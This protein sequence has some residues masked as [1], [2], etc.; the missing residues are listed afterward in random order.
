[1]HL[2]VE[3]AMS[4]SQQFEV[5]SFE[6][7]DGM[8][9]ELSLL[10]S[11][12]EAT[13][14]RLAL[15]S[16]V[17][18]AARSLN[19][20]YTKKGRGSESESPQLEKRHRR[21]IFGSRGSGSDLLMQTDDELTASNRKCEELAQELWRL[22]KR[23]GEI[24]MRLLHHTAGILQMTHKNL[25]KDGQNGRPSSPESMLMSDSRGSVP[26]LV[27]EFDERSLYRMLDGTDDFGGSL[28]PQNRSL[29]Q[30][31]S[32]RLSQSPE[33]A[34]Q[35]DTII[36]TEKKLEHLNSRLRV[37]IMHASQSQD[38]PYEAPPSHQVNGS[39]P[40]PGAVIESQLAYL[41]KGLETIDRQSSESL[42]K[43]QEEEL[44]LE[45]R[46]EELNHQLH[47]IIES[48]PHQ[49]ADYHP[50]PQAS[51]QTLQSQLDYLE[52]GMDTI[53]QR[54][55]G[56]ARDA[57]RSS[58][59]FTG[60][61]EKV[62]QYNT[63]LMG[64]WEIILSGEEEARQRRRE[65][66]ETRSGEDSDVSQEESGT[67][68]QEFS[69]QVFSAKVQSLYTQATGLREQKKS[70]YKQLE[71]QRSQSA[72]SDEH[73]EGELSR[74]TEELE[75]TKVV[76]REI[77]KKERSAREE[78]EE[79]NRSLID[80]EKEARGA[81]EE[82]MVVM[83]RLDEARRESNFKEHQRTME[84]S[85]AMKAEK[86]ARR[87]AEE[88][89][90]AELQQ[91]KQKQLEITKLEDQ[92]INLK[93]DTDIERKEM[94]SQIG[95]CEARIREL[96]E[97]LQGANQAKTEAE[98]AKRKMQGL[99]AERTKEVERVEGEMVRLN[100]EVTVAKAELD[101]AYGTR[102]QRA[103]DVATNPAIQ[104]E[105]DELIERN[106]SLLEEIAAL[107]AAK[108]SAGS[109]GTGL[110]QRVETLQRELSETIS[111]YETMTKSSIEFEKE[112][113]QLEGVIDDLRDRCEELEAKLSDEKVRWLG[114]KSP[115]G[116]DAPP[117]STSTTVLK[118]EF[119]KMM[120]DTRAENSKAIR[121]SCL[122]SIADLWMLL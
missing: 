111:D 80:S 66:G 44:V 51:G 35:T 73:K 75:H 110:Q 3:T 1:M 47:N 115:G 120:R 102:A 94:Q 9:K 33:Y 76:L 84:L 43:T 34:Q 61:Q 63:V 21:S 72:E 38:H 48:Q 64:L 87:E 104:K 90:A 117:Q 45:E 58:T 119:K 98:E 79:G 42:K 31:P 77:D 24:Q 49:D 11:R 32:R 36:A 82:L 29:S 118:N 62:G 103:A 95:L 65:K 96:A 55:H 12:V 52:E 78:I 122:L 92:L 74:L 56:M 27:E 99:L 20:L 121:V 100:T 5:V 10:N 6:E 114:M 67:S 22:E 101:G 13:R 50:P 54:L 69:L 23:A 88:E 14:R 28:R 40:D 2:L 16:K 109:S 91:L 113:E 26:T 39:A 116:E 89:L 86:E 7:V 70:L 68:E 4:D 8:K 83:K 18:D 30:S 71:Q 97:Q 57:E 53:E 112:R 107:K 37:V 41:E 17:H 106:S 60:Y 81:R 19:R 15:E 93:D 46:L 59:K 108:D 25:S 85:A 105:L